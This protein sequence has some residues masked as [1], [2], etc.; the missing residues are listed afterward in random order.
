M[1]TKRKSL[2]GI[3]SRIET[4]E[5]TE[6]LLA[7]VKHALSPSDIRIKLFQRAVKWG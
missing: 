3:L 1:S 2:L 4:I 7:K 6:S 5:C